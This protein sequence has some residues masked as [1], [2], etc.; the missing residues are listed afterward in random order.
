[1]VL[2]FKERFEGGTREH[3]NLERPRLRGEMQSNDITGGY[4]YGGYL[5]AAF[6]FWFFLPDNTEGFY[7]FCSVSPRVIHIGTLTMEMFVFLFCFF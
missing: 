5:A 7:G 2:G 6:R 3:R 1:M 4:L